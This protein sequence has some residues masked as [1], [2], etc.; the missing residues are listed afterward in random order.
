MLARLSPGFCGAQR[1]FFSSSAAARL[2]LLDSDVV[3]ISTARTPITSA[4]SGAL[5]SVPA[6]RLGAAAISAA[7]TRAVEKSVGHVTAGDL[8]KLVSE[9]L[10]GH[11]VSANVGQA[12][13]T[14]A[15]HFAGLPNSVAGSTINKVC[16]S[17]M[18][19]VML[20]SLTLR[21]SPS[22]LIVAGGMES[23]SNV[24]YYSN[25]ALRMGH[26]SLVDGVLR[27]GLQDPFDNS[28]MGIAGEHCAKTFNIS[29][30]DQDTFALESYRRAQLAQANGFFSTEIAPFHV[31]GRAPVTVSVD[32]EP[33]KLD[34][35]KFARLKPAFLPGGT[36]T[37][38][39]ASK[40]NDGA[41]ALLLT[42][43]GR[44]REL[45][46]K[47]QARVR[48]FA[49]AARASIEF[50]I[51]PTDALRKAFKHA[52]LEQSDVQFYETNEAF[53]VVVLANNRIMG[54]DNAKVN[55]NGGAIA[56]GHPIGCSGARIISSLLHVLKQNDGTLGAA[57]IC[58]GGGG[59]SA[60]I[61]ERLQ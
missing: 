54:L 45:G 51:A 31:Q 10:M 8:N 2:Q 60:L 25:R 41:A 20:A 3:I 58:N 36:I 34:P 21:D 7:L 39:N 59:A 33:D 9:V 32:E 14:Q 47:P 44:A 6:P 43:A 28:A 4:F 61:I 38:G 18:K 5:A 49:D 40:I 57:S 15:A 50:T 23:M 52:N 12:P 22:E 24:P 46:L 16:A 26:A 56:L 53:S 27:D 48:G 55:V 42:T 30:Q 17:G 35:A 37:A 29:R 13:A 1:A 19:A 11:V